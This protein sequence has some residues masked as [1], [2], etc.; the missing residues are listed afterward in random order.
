MFVVAGNDFLEHGDGIGDDVGAIAAVIPGLGGDQFFGLAEYDGSGDGAPVMVF[1]EVLGGFAPLGADAA[2]VYGEILLRAVVDGSGVFVPDIFEFCQVG[3]GEHLRFGIFGFEVALLCRGHGGL[4][5]GVLSAGAFVEPFCFSLRPVVGG[6][7]DA[8]GKFLYADVEGV[9]GEK[10]G[11]IDAVL[12]VGVFGYF[13]D[14][15]FA[16]FGGDDGEFHL[17]EDFFQ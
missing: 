13:L 3:F 12:G 1:V 5:V 14:C 11:G 6:R 17:D 4:C 2:G 8:A 15:V 7:P 9:V 10:V 16:L